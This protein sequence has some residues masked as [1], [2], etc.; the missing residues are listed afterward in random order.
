M[1]IGEKD[2]IIGKIHTVISD[3]SK[4]V[5]FYITKQYNYFTLA[6]KTFFFKITP[7]STAPPKFFYI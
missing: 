3:F 7:V 5:F 1:I 2:L 6:L 4:S